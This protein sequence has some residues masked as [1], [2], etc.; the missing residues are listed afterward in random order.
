MRAQKLQKINDRVYLNS[1]DEPELTNSSQGQQS[2]NVL[3]SR[4]INILNGDTVP[5][6]NKRLR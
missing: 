5:D 1:E 4:L 6:S 2:E 3:E